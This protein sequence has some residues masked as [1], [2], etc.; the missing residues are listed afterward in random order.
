MV[1]G[2]ILCFVDEFNHH[3]RTIETQC[4]HDTV[5]NKERLEHEFKLLYEMAR[6]NTSLFEGSGS[7]WTNSRNP[8]SYDAHKY[9]EYG[10][11][12]FIASTIQ[13]GLTLYVEQELEIRHIR[14][15]RG[16]PLLDYTLRPAMM[17]PLESSVSR[18]GPDPLMVQLL[19]Q[20]GADPNQR[21][22][23]A[24]VHTVWTYFI[25]MFLS[26]CVLWGQCDLQ[27]AA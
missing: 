25:A 27:T 2:D 19:L 14:E 20:R 3:A 12:T 16:R 17:S 24:K 1:N 9:K 21:M 18:G 22:Y 6:V 4:S 15:K 5:Q 26:S 13:A 10:F 23:K 7:H 8:P 11:H